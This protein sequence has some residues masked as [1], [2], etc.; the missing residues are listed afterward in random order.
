MRR[1]EKEIQDQA[2]LEKIL[3][4]GAVVRIAMASS[5]EPYLVPMSYGYHNGYLYLH[6]A[7]EGKKIDM[8]RNNPHICFEVSEGIELVSGE[9]ACRFGTSYRSVIGM[10]KVEILQ[11]SEEKRAGLQVLMSQHSNKDDW[12][13]SDKAVEA[14]TVWKIRIENMTGKSSG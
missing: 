9:E 5:D 2:E 3:N 14:V 4:R 11:S 13:F 1:K 12:T 7:T 6:S 8:I 10:G